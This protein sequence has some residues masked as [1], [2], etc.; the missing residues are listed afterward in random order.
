MMSLESLMRTHSVLQETVHVC[1]LVNSKGLPSTVPV[2][3]SFQ[4]PTT[5]VPQ[6]NYY[7]NLI[8]LD[9][10]YCSFH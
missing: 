7:K 4:L 3:L 8:V 5:T 2:L 1:E 10:L 6:R 9:Y